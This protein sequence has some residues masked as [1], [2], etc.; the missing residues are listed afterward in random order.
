MAQDDDRSREV[1]RILREPT[2][3]THRLLPLVYDQ[4]REI[5]GRRMGGERRGHT[6][7]ATGLVH[8]TYLR[9]LAGQRLGWESK[10]H[11]FAAAA[12]AMRRILVDHA[13]ARDR[14]KRGGGRPRLPLDVVDL[15]TRED[16]EEILSVEEAIRRLEMRDERLARVV[17]LRFY[18]G[19]SEEETAQA[20][21]VT[22]RTVRRDWTLAR[23]FLQRE[24]DA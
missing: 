3:D 8:E 6:L 21:G 13:R 14:V 22:D 19:L 16:P 2:V 1:S 12:E 20:L 15:A 18:A 4:L 23:A 5:A 17:K 10:A 9:M 24:L 7:D 11:F